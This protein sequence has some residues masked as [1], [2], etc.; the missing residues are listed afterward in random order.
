MRIRPGVSRSSFLLRGRLLQ[1]KPKKQTRGTPGSPRQGARLQKSSKPTRP[2]LVGRVYF[3]RP[4]RWGFFSPC[5]MFLRTLSTTQENDTVASIRSD[6]LFKHSK[7]A[8][9]EVIY[10]GKWADVLN[11]VR[12]EDVIT[13]T[14]RN[15]DTACSA[16]DNTPLCLG[17]PERDLDVVVHRIFPETRAVMCASLSGNVVQRMEQHAA[18]NYSPQ[19]THSGIEIDENLLK[20]TNQPQT[21]DSGG[22]RPIGSTYFPAGLEGISQRLR[23]RTSSEPRPACG[24]PATRPAARGGRKLLEVPAAEQ[25]RNASHRAKQTSTVHISGHIQRCYRQRAESDDMQN[26]G[27]VFREPYTARVDSQPE[28]LPPELLEAFELLQQVTPS[29]ERNNGFERKTSKPSGSRLHSVHENPSKYPANRLQGKPGDQMCYLSGETKGSSVRPLRNPATMGISNEPYV[30]LPETQNPYTRQMFPPPD[31]TWDMPSNFH[32]IVDGTLHSSPRERC[33]E[34]RNPHENGRSLGATSA[35]NHR[36]PLAGEGL[37]YRSGGTHGAEGGSTENRGP[38][39]AEFTYNF[40]GKPVALFYPEIYPDRL[41]MTNEATDVPASF[42]PNLSG[43]VQRP[44]AV[45][46]SWVPGMLEGP[47]TFSSTWVRSDGRQVGIEPLMQSRVSIS[48]GLHQTRSLIDKW[49]LLQ[50][51]IGGSRLLQS[52]TLR[53][54][55]RTSAVPGF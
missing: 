38:P 9:K 39:E 1:Q 41:V 49:Q 51:Q 33:K 27:P 3:S 50:T 28:S 31:G 30:R 12:Q 24:S 10:C 14:Y 18:E 52:A 8:S 2:Q 55:N 19:W 13:L 45:S 54:V 16:G 20:E 11:F 36:I 21:Q 23:S 53:P 34:S 37:Q 43:Q 25:C 15:A 17:D 32:A 47:A 5:K 6:L 46:M 48:P 22:R 40:S 44:C 7:T 35:E 42:S 26:A 4:G 29:V